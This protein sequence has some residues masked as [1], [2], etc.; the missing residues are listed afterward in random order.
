MSVWE[1][2]VLPFRRKDK[3]GGKIVNGE[4]E[5]INA[6][7]D[8]DSQENPAMRT[9]L[10]EPSTDEE[11]L[12]AISDMVVQTCMDIRRGENVLIV[13]DPTTSEIGQ[14]LHIAT[15]KRTDRVLL[16]VMPK[17]R[18]HG[19]EPPTPVAALMRQQQV[20]I[21]ATKYSLTHTKAAR[22]ALKDGARIATMPGM[23]F[24]LYT[25]GGM[26]ADFQDVK[27]RISNIANVLRRR[28]IINVKSETGTDVTF[29]VNWRDWKLDDNGI[30]NRP[31][32]LTNLPAGKVF[33]LPKEGTMNG[34]IVID[35]SWDSTLI[36][37]P[38]ELIV[39]NGT[40]IDVKGGSLAAT[41]RQSYGEVAKKL[42]A[43]DRES[44]WMTAEFGFGMNPSAR[45]VGNVLE[46]EKRMGSC[47]FSIGDN[48][49]LGG[50]SH[51]GIHVSGVLAKPTVWLDDTCL[52]ESGKFMAI[53]D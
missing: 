4:D 48:S 24:E 11:R 34:T 45:L 41:I 12:H 33:I 2:M 20:V 14:S 15:Q 9:S 17:S 37:E 1:N 22:Q 51:A 32:M 43:K 23:T 39:E 6:L 35:G 49:R 21:A 36:D 47:Y 8:A 5:D 50:S 46:D 18:H 10:P 28:R 53:D 19:E 3:D 27:R 25:E 30:C 7:L 29:E 16:I 44:V 52:T 40:V 42:K 38:V 31:R 26:T 13:C